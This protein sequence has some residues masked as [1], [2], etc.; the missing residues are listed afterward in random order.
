[1][2]TQAFAFEPKK[3]HQFTHDPE[4]IAARFSPC[5]LYLFGHGYDG[6]VQ[7]WELAT[8][9][10]TSLTGHSAWV[11]ALA[12]HPDGQLMFT[13]DSWGQVCC[14]N[15]ADPAP[16]PLWTVSETHAVWP[17]GLAVSPDGGWLATCG[18][19]RL[20]KLWS[21]ADGLLK[22]ELPPLA[23]EAFTVLF[24]PD[25]KSLVC[26]DLKGVV[27]QWSFEAE[28]GAGALARELDAGQLYLRPLQSGVP[29]IND[30][31]GVRSLAFDAAGS[32]LAAAGTIPLSSGFV[33]GKPAIVV[34][35][36][37]SGAVQETIQLEGASGNEGFVLDVA[38]HPQGFLMAACSGQPGQGAVWLWRLGEKAPFYFNK[39]LTHSR[40]V[41][42]HPDGKRLAVTQVVN[43]PG[44]IQ[45][46][47]RVK[48]P[49]QAYLGQM[50]HVH[51][52]ET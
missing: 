36:W 1:M 44:A 21:T 10:K 25:G 24:H 11:T 30:V 50:A 32:L 28:T 19:D 20:V 16:A 17:R 14:W 48:D 12:F 23:S 49:Q 45:G 22:Q 9:Q 41:S 38:W 8:E 46:N 3:V 2:P 5:G 52:F 13:A 7:R 40:S 51:V 47:D 26:G 37:A 31:G 43:I 18:A 4:L 42:L 29:E 34:F 35:N 6:Q 15:Y 27:R 33:Q 39:E